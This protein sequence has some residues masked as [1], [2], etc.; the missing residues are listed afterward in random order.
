MKWAELLDRLRG[1]TGLT[2]KQVASIEK[3]HNWRVFRK[4]KLEA[5]RTGS[6]PIDLVATNFGPGGMRA[7][8][9]HKL[10]KDDTLSI[11]LAPGAGRLVVG[12]ERFQVKVVWVR[13]RKSDGMNEVGL[14]FNAQEA[15]NRLSAARFLLEQCNVSIQNPKEKRTAPRV[16]AERMT[17]AFAGDDGEVVSAQVVDL[18]VGGVQ[19]LSPR[20][21]PRGAALDLRISLAPD[22]PPLLCKGIVLRSSKEGQLRT[23]ELGVAFTEVPSDHK[24][25]LISFLGRLLRGE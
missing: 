15:D 6:E 5:A 8:T 7:E 19:L 16:Q 20:M 17:A 24:D 12:D 21:V 10:K 3:R 9:S 4:I 1:T 11:R 23:V 14:V 2:D 22:L 18:A 13:R 25:R